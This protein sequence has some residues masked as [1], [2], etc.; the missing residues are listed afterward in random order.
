M[1]CLWKNDGD[2]VLGRWRFVTSDDDRVPLSW[3]P[4][5]SHRVS[6]G[7]MTVSERPAA[8]YFVGPLVVRF[9]AYF[10]IFGLQT[11]SRGVEPAYVVGHL[12]NL[13]LHHQTLFSRQPIF[14]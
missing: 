13:L 12:Q 10:L 5:P 9:F 14:S 4:T 3:V 8:K 11:V 7:L 1:G 2:Y 6:V